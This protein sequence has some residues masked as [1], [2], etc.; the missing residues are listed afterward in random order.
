MI[1]TMYSS[2]RDVSCKVGTDRGSERKRRH[3]QDLSQQR[4]TVIFCIDKQVQKYDRERSD[5]IFETLSSPH[6]INDYGF[7]EPRVC[8]C[9]LAKNYNGSKKVNVKLTLGKQI[10]Y[11]PRVGN[12]KLTNKNDFS[13]VHVIRFVFPLGPLNLLRQPLS[14]FSVS[15]LK[16]KMYKKTHLS[17]KRTQSSSE[18]VTFRKKTDRPTSRSVAPSLVG[19]GL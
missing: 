16:E 17:L 2:S 3:K 8:V 15:P 5:L 12:E 14:L 7:Y 11:F 19:T 6:N 13:L 4:Q 9:Y 1:V 18:Y 10:S